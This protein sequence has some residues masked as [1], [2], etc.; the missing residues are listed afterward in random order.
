MKTEIDWHYCIDEMPDDETR[1]LVACESGEVC[2]G[3]HEG[4]LWV[5]DNMDGVGELP[6]VYAWAHL[7]EP[8]PQ[9]VVSA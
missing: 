1:V 8:A 7:P 3:W 2:E 5:S 9:P 6:G 4:S